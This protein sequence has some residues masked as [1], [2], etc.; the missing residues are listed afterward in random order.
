MKRIFSGIQPSGNIHIGNY[1]GAIKQW[2]EMSANFDESIYCI[3]DLHA[4]TV[5]QDPK[6]LSQKILEI[7]ALYIASGIDPEKSAI[8]VQSSRPEHTELTWMLN[9]QAKMG[10]LYRMTQFKDKSAKASAESAGVGLFDY[11]VLMA[12]DILLYQ[13]THVPVGEDQK[14]HVELTRDLAQRFNSHFGETF[15]IPEPVIKKTAAR[16][17]G[18][19]DPTKKM[20]KSAISPLN[21]IAMTDSADMIRQKIKKAVT[22]SGSEI[23]AGVDKPAMTNLLNIFSEISDKTIS[24]IEEQ[25]AGRGYGDFKNALADAL[26]A[27]LEPI[28]QRYYQLISDQDG[29]KAIL[30]NGAERIKPLAA[31]TVDD[32]KAKMGLGI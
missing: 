5:P 32:V 2:V 6:E 13:A 14:Q 9:C 26:V 27:Y 19:D 10:E 28:Q 20:S 11:P 30:R 23:K 8:F 12:A 18:L 24:E 22:D 4:I 21:Y 17:M 25:F 16:I 15:V 7:A 1:L 31:E 29:L 3:V